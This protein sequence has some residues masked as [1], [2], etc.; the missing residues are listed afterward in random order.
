MMGG[1]S[2]RC[3]NRGDAEQLRRGRGLGYKTWLRD[4]ASAE[5]SAG[6]AGLARARLSGEDLEGKDLEGKDLR[7]FLRDSAERGRP[8]AGHAATGTGHEQH[9]W[10]VSQTVTGANARTVNPSVVTRGY[11]D[12]S[13]SC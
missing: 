5:A 8:G 4:G 6:S 13:L 9:G 3:G 1:C 12:A 2:C 11:T 10:R 7:L